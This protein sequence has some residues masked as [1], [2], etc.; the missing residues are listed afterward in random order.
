M[1]V[2]NIQTVRSSIKKLEKLSDGNYLDLELALKLSIS[3][4]GGWV[5]EK[6]HCIVFCYIDK[7]IN[8]VTLAKEVKERVRHRSF[9][10][11]Y[12]DFRKKIGMILSE[13]E[14]M[15]LETKIN[16]KFP[17]GLNHFKQLLGELSNERNNCQHSYIRSGRS[18][19]RFGFSQIISKLDEINSV[20]KIIKAFVHNKSL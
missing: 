3:E 12:D 6:I 17:P 5:E 13:A 18:V 4:A 19:I 15:A 14:I 8:K 2:I 20:F 9:G 1:T 16:I 10:F 11:F 7:T